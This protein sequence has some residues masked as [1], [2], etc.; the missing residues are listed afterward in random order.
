MWTRYNFFHRYLITAG[1]AYIKKKVK[2]TKIA[3]T[4]L[5]FL[6]SYSG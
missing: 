6:I 3:L 4:P 2:Y 5:L 1:I